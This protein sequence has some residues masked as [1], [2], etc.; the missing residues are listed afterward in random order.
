MRSLELEM[1]L[2]SEHYEYMK[3]VSAAEMTAPL[4][5]ETKLGVTCMHLG[6]SDRGASQDYSCKFKYLEGLDDCIPHNVILS[7][8]GGFYGVCSQIYQ[9]VSGMWKRVSSA[10]RAV[11]IEQLV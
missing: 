10:S 9:A 7:V 2:Q 5:W 3:V 6:Y 1:M 11:G 8:K 4:A